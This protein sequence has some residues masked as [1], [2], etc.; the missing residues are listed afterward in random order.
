MISVRELAYTLGA[1]VVWQADTRSVLVS[2][3]TYSHTLYIDVSL[4]HGM[5]K[6]LIV[7]GTTYVPLRYVA[8][9]LGATVRWDN[10]DRIVSVYM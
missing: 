2:T 9:T 8:E 1:E 4:P 5:G 3:S 6:P 7:E 10:T